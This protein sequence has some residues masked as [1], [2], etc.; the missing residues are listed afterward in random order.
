[1]GAEGVDDGGD[2]RVDI[3]ELGQ[4]AERD[5]IMGRVEVVQRIMLAGRIGAGIEHPALALG[6]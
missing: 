2:D 1:M 6:P 4:T 3:E 5:L